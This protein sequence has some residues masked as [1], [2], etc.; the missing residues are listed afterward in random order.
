[1]PDEPSFAYDVFLSQ[2]A[3]DKKIVREIAE[4]LEAGAE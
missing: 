1:M 4:S 2:S 3:K